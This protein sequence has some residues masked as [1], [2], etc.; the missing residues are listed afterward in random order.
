MCVCSLTFLGLGAVGGGDLCCTSNRASATLS[1]TCGRSSRPPTWPEAPPPVEAMEPVDRERGRECWLEEM[2]VQASSSSV[3][4]IS[5]S[6]GGLLAFC[7]CRHREGSEW[8]A[9]IVRA[10]SQWPCRH[11]EEGHADAVRAV[12]GPGVI[13]GCGSCTKNCS[14]LTGGGLGGTADGKPPN[15]AANK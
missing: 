5:N 9:D 2:T 3:T 1:I 4:P 6:E 13:K 15:T 7:F 10:V 14:Q 11:S 8:H 12:S